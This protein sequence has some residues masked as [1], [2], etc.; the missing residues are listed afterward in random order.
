MKITVFWT[1]MLHSLV[2]GANILVEPAISFFIV[3]HFSV[4]ATLKIEAA[5]SSK[6]FVNSPTC[7]HIR[8]NNNIHTHCEK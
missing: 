6:L 7:H 2:K 5:G 3:G 1:M 4:S 8:E